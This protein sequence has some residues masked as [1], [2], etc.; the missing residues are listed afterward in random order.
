MIRIKKRIND[1][2]KNVDKNNDIEK[3]ISTKVKK[4]FIY[5]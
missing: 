1:L 2:R 4:Y 3:N 5:V